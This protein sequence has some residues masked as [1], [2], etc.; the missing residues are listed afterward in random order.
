MTEGNIKRSAALF[1]HLH[2]IIYKTIVSPKN[3]VRKN[4]LQI[5]DGRIASLNSK[6]GNG[7]NRGFVQKIIVGVRSGCA[8][9]KFIIAAQF[10]IYIIGT[11]ANKCIA[12]LHT[13]IAAKNSGIVCIIN[14]TL[15]YY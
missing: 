2:F 11:I 8:M 10:Y 9:G 3:A 14:N 15:L 12:G 7:Y 13:G 5:I 1:A 6:V 4:G